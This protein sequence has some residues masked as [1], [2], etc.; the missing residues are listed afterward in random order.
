MTRD[1]ALE[2][3]K[4][5]IVF[6]I[7]L[8]V[9]SIGVGFS[10]HADLGT[11]PVSSVPNVISMICNLTMGEITI[12]MHCVFIAIQI[13]LLRK[14]FKLRQ[15]SQLLVA[16]VFGYFTD[17]GL[18][19]TAW[20]RP[21]N[22]LM[23]WVYVCISFFI[24]AFGV[25]LEV[26]AK[27]LLLAGEGLMLAISQV[28]H[29]EFGKVKI[30]VDCGQVAVAVGISLISMHTL[31]GVREGTIAAAILVGTIVRIYTKKLKFV[32][33]FLGNTPEGEASGTSEETAPQPQPHTVVTIARQYGSGG[34]DIGREV[35]KRLGFSY[36]DDELM[37]MAVKESGLSKDYVEQHE[38]AARAIIYRVYQ[39]NYEYV[40]EETPSAEHLF[41]TQ[42]RIIEE[43]AKE[44]DCVIVGRLANF[45]LA[46]HP[47]ALH[48]FV[49][50]S[51]QFRIQRIMQYESTDEKT[52]R[53]RMQK[54]DSDRR[55]HCKVCTG[56]KWGDPRFYTIVVDAS[57]TGVDAAADMIAL[58]AQRLNTREI[59]K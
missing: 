5:Y 52:A 19:L 28:T 37:K 6:G 12:L 38:E 26:H 45:I 53:R 8:F 55:N 22:Y 43:L 49:H 59:S 16:V 33:R 39:Q 21:Q 11:S 7:S 44:K 57:E 35:A 32:D 10:V 58:I 23:Q 9:M 30:G 47:K 40:N 24:I 42:K 51:E 17:L 31:K 1:K 15:L 56:E 36:V 46:G 34:R 50:G 13:L 48:V 2:M 25:Y 54:V 4:R 29:I 41:E 18:A 27:C 20:V 14:N 3:V